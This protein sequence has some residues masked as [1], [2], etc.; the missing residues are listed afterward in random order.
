LLDPFVDAI[1]L[2]MATGISEDGNRRWSS[3]ESSPKDWREIVRH[4]L[5]ISSED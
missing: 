4:K 1:Y 5:R 2:R 3:D